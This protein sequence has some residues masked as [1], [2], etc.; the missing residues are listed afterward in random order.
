MGAT[1][2]GGSAP[3]LRVYVAG[4]MAGLPD[5]NFPAFHVAADALRSNGYEVISPAE[6]ATEAELAEGNRLGAAFRETQTYRECLKRDLRAVLDCDAVQL[7][8]GWEASRGAQLEVSVARAVGI[9][10]WDPA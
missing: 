3:R 2:F 8:P 9:D 1:V 6:L 10:V 7:L 4:P 5:H